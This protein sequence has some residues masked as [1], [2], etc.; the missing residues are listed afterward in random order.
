MPQWNHDVGRLEAELQSSFLPCDAFEV[1][2]WVWLAT[3]FS[4]V[5]G[6]T[7]NPADFNHQ[8]PELAACVLVQRDGRF[9][10]GTPVPFGSVGESALANLHNLSSALIISAALENGVTKTPTQVDHFSARLRLNGMLI[11]GPAY[12]WQEAE[13]TRELF[14]ESWIQDQLVDTIG[15]SSSDA[16]SLAEFVSEFGLARFGKVADN[17]N[18]VANEAR[19]YLG[20]SRKRDTSTTARPLPAELL[21]RLGDVPAAVIPSIVDKIPTLIA[22]RDGPGALAFTAHDLSAAVDLDIT[23]VESFLRLFSTP[24]GNRRHVGEPSDRRLLSLARELSARPLL[25]DQEGNYFCASPISMVWAVRPALQQAVMDTSSKER[26]V[27]HRAKRVELRAA[28]ALEN[29]L[30]PDHTRVNLKFREAD[31][32]KEDFELDVLLQIDGLA[33]VAECKSGT[34]RSPIRQG[35]KE[36]LSQWLH[37]DLDGAIS[38]VRRAKSAL[39]SGALFSFRGPDDKAMEGI[40]NS[41]HT[42]LPIV[43]VLDD[44]SSVTTE[45]WRLSTTEPDDYGEVPWIVG[46]FDL[47]LICS[48]TTRPADLIHFIRRRLDLNSHGRASA[49]DELDYYMHYIERGLFWHPDSE[50]TFELIGSHTE[51]LDAYIAYQR[52]ESNGPAEVPTPP[53]APELTD[54]LERLERERPVGWL[55]ASVTILDL[56]VPERQRAL[57][58]MARVRAKSQLDHRLHDETRM[59]GDTGITVISGT[60]TV[61]LAAKVRAYSQWKLA[62]RQARRWVTFGLRARSDKNYD[63]LYTAEDGMW[64]SQ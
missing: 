50:P 49:V 40:P 47:E 32:R 26:F 29:A 53:H 13:F 42:V 61:E 12:A 57:D 35:I 44:M 24:F 30:R 3:M 23:V 43:V 21:A 64:R 14:H 8:I 41:I 59:F 52:G 62:K 4:P 34:V 45:A 39:L 1:L 17:A 9:E 2:A 11:K 63:I 55:T 27:R 51:R 33:I 46:L 20:E 7:G 38:Q 28:Q 6:A 48:V 56:D 5:P 18:A 54:L 31:N 25:V 22:L 19:R 16:V 10:T 60:D 58:A 15:L 37:R 36:P